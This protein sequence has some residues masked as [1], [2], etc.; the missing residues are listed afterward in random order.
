MCVINVLSCLTGCLLRCDSSKLSL[1]DLA[2]SEKMLAIDETSLRAAEHLKE[3]TS[4]NQSLSSLGNVIAALASKHRPHIPYR[5][6]K[7]TRI[8]QDSLGGNTRTILISCVAPTVIHAAESV[9]TLQFAGGRAG[10]MNPM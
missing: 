9:S 1:V 3:L 10:R 2:G 7:L 4:I 8:L 5:D 6:S